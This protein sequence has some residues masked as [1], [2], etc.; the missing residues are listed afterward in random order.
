MTMICI[1]MP[2]CRPAVS[3]ML[4]ALGWLAPLS[5]STSARGTHGSSGPRR[6]RFYGA[7]NYLRGGSN[8]NNNNNNNDNDNDGNYYNSRGRHGSRG[9]HNNDKSSSSHPGSGYIRNYSSGTWEDAVGAADVDSWSQ[10]RILG[11]GGATSGVVGGAAAAAVVVSSSKSGG[12]SG[13]GDSF[14]FGAGANEKALEEF[15]AGADDRDLLSS[16]A[17]DDGVLGYPMRALS[18]KSGITVTRT[19]DITNGR[20]N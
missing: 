2:V 8:N 20:K 13:S 10:R 3:S 12:S 16:G 11:I 9:H 6:R 4:Q 15:G 17:V 14:S 5:H 18:K 19:V 7:L 1:G